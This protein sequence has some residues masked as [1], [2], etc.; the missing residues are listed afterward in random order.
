MCIYIYIYIYIHTCNTWNALYI[1]IYIHVI[2][3]CIYMAIR[4]CPFA[5][6]LTSHSLALPLAR[7]VLRLGSRKHKRQNTLRGKIV[8]SIQQNITWLHAK[9]GSPLS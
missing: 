5:S 6:L 8:T 9:R 3:T 4:Y 2:H 7:A 1:Y